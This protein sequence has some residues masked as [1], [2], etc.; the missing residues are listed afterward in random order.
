MSDRVSR[1]NFLRKASVAASAS[2]LAACQPKVVEVTKV[3]EKEVVVAGTP[4]IV[5]ETVVVEV[6]KEVTK[7]VEKPE[8]RFQYTYPTGLIGGT[9]AAL[10]MYQKF[11]DE[12]GIHIRHEE[13][14]ADAINKIIAGFAA[15]TAPDVFATWGPDMRNLIEKG[16]CLNLDSFIERDWGKEELADFVESQLIATQ[17]DGH[18]FGVPRYCGIWAT[19]YNVDLFEQA[20]I[21][22]PDKE[23]WDYQKFLDASVAITKRDADG[24]P[25]QLGYDANW[26][27]EFTISTAIWSWGGEIHDPE[28]NRICRLSDPKSMEA[29]QFMADLRWKH[30]GAATPSDVSALQTA[31]FALFST[32]KV[33]INPNG[34]WRIKTYVP[35]VKQRFL[36]RVVPHWKGPTGQRV[37]FS[38][39]D[40][41][42]GNGRTKVPEETWQVLKWL[43][44][45]EYQRWMMTAA[46][47][48]PAR[49]SLAGEFVK[50]AR[51][52]AMEA[53]PAHE[54]TD[55]EVF[56]EGFDYCRP[57]IYFYNHSQ[58]M[59]ILQP[60]MD[61]IF[62]TGT[63]SV[64]E[65]IP[66]AC[67]KV[68][69][70]LMS[71]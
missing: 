37:T 63:G 49:K 53:N 45:P 71:L 8:V 38:T 39:T 1:R 69:N 64:E 13:A 51:E 19:Y 27:L 50:L 36:W 14:P 41:F 21:P 42:L 10:A 48:Q 56:V 17:K 35:E 15:G 59:E 7:V 55:F 20:N 31:E 46:T 34:S 44:G 3:V 22:L 52:R 40:S 28:D 9:N 16:V 43:S 68:T 58:A 67:E 25:I 65:L 60:V 29:M 47:D 54:D 66:E 12:T 32:G 70:L 57:M 61:Q 33:G 24:A 62:V 2:L 30:G 4:Q 18:Q 5:K 26:A 23:T 11:E 6:E